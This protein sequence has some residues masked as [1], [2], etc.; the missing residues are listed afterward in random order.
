MP[1]A[2]AVLRLMINSTFVELL[3]RQVGRL[4]AFQNPADV[5]A[6]QAECRWD[7]CSITHQA[8]RRRKFAIGRDRWDEVVERQRSEL[9]ALAVQESVGPDHQAA[10]QLRRR[11][12]SPIE[13]G[14]CT[15]LYDLEP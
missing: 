7:T 15:C 5:S 6:S 1:S 9:S 4:L 3:D 13:F 12:K 2:L 8:A 14:F 11:C 10:G